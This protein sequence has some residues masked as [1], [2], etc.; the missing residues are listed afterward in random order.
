MRVENKV[1]EGR[2][3][4]WHQTL[5][6]I[7]AL[8]LLSFCAFSCRGEDRHDDEIAQKDAESWTVT[9]HG[10]VSYPQQGGSI[11]IQRIS[12]DGTGGWQ[13]TIQ[14]KSDNTFSKKVTMNEPGYYRLNFY[15]TQVLNV[16]LD[17][18]D[19]EVNVD[20][21]NPQGFFE[22]KGS[23]DLDLIKQVQD[24]LA[25]ANESPE[26]TKINE[27]FNAAAQRNDEARMEAIRAEY[28]TYIQKTN[29]Q[30]ADLMVKHS[31]SLAV[32]NLLKSGTIDRDQYFDTYMKVAENLRAEWPN[33]GVAREFIKHV[34]TMK[35]T[36]V[37]QPAPEIALPNPQGEVIKL[38]S[39]KGKYV[40]VDFWTKWC[41][42]CR[43]ENPNV[44]KA[45]NKYKDKG[46]TVY[47]VSLDRTRE[48]WLQAIEEDNL[49]WTHVSDLKFW[50]S[51]AAKT[52][53]ITAIPFS[54]L[55]DP[56]GVIIA[57]NLRGTA[58]DKKLAEIFEG[59]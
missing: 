34:E 49:T 18:S 23:P 31:P 44:V 13:D 22:I 35:A 15:N 56:N 47:G 8:I 21:N 50:Q 3:L 17:R 37:G 38:S 57:K 4:E 29:D 7:A 59:K 52:Y 6:S 2:L 10:K 25:A 33:Y 19:I 14:L 41:G 9:V 51:E 45:Y 1:T 32:I 39:L 28:Y 58:L 16:I 24:L 43:R 55:L 46:F 5:L 54:I 30:I 48:D 42:P 12:E 40:L 36:A 27:A 20:G 53:G 11:S 26:M